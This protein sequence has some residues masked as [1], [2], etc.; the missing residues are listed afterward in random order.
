M[1]CRWYGHGCVL[2]HGSLPPHPGMPHG[3][4][5]PGMP[6]GIMAAIPAFPGP[7]SGC[8]PLPFFLAC[9]SS[10]L[11]PSSMSGF[12]RT[13]LACG[14]PSP[15]ISTFASTRMPFMSRPATRASGGA[16]KCTSPSTWAVRIKPTP[17]VGKYRITTP[18]HQPTSRRGS[19][20]SATTGFPLRS[21]EPPFSV[22]ITSP[23]LFGSS[24]RKTPRHH[25][26]VPSLGGFI[27]FLA[28]ASLTRRWTTASARFPYHS[29]RSRS[30][31]SL[32]CSGTGCT[33]TTQSSLWASFA[34]SGRRDC[35]GAGGKA[36]VPLASP[37]CT[38]TPAAGSSGSTSNGR[39]CQARSWPSGN[40]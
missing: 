5:P 33:Q 32:H 15:P 4:I 3:A 12:R 2:N 30:S 23:A 38:A 16:S 22:R 28:H 35:G 20:T 1:P 36:W 21:R 7:A 9:P 10:G 8:R 39:T 18:W 34:S 25:A 19:P 29:K 26:G 14:Q 27:L 11:P 40:R 31:T 24:K 17:N 13:S 37:A 6:P